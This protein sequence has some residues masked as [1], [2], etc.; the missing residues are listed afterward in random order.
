MIDDEKL[1]DVALNFQANISNNLLKEN[2]EL[3]KEIEALQTQLK[4]SPE[5][6]NK[7]SATESMLKADLISR[8][9]AICA[10]A[11]SELRNDDYYASGMLDFS[12]Q[13]LNFLL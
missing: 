10:I 7:D 9:A 13:T 6:F 1:K 2:M 11:K 12:S 5:I 8:R 4:E 3:K